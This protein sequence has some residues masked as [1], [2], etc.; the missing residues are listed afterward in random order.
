MEAYL[1]APALERYLTTASANRDF[2]GFPGL[3]WENPL[4][5]WS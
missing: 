3:Q 2:A 1:A 4:A 5:V